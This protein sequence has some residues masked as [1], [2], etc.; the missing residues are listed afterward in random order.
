MTE[1]EE[2]RK[3]II[4]Q[5]SNLLMRNGFTFEY[6]I[7]KK[8]KGIKVIFEVTQE[9]LSKIIEQGRKEHEQDYDRK[10]NQKEV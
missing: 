10:R 4:K 9:Q 1:T 2:Q 5:I 6:V 8:P 7:R 3:K